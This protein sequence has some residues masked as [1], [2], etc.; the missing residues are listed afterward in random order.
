MRPLS[1]KQKIESLITVKLVKLA[2]LNVCL[3]IIGFPFQH[4]LWVLTELNSIIKWTSSNH[5]SLLLVHISIGIGTSVVFL[6]QD[7]IVFMHNA[8][9][10][11]SWGCKLQRRGWQCV[12]HEKVHSDV[13]CFRVAGRACWKIEMQ[14]HSELSSNPLPVWVN[15]SKPIQ[16]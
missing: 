8:K 12:K 7:W 16:L 15:N 10:T 14:S 9:I 3:E 6:Q 4:L 13:Y 2:L 11:A 1:S 5:A